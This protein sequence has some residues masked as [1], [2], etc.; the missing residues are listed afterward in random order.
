MT[1]AKMFPPQQEED[2][3]IWKSDKPNPAKGKFNQTQTVFGDDVSTFLFVYIY[4]QSYVQVIFTSLNGNTYGT[5]YRLS[6][7]KSSGVE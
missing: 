7:D 5:K 4:N 2:D 1:L 3:E 6:G